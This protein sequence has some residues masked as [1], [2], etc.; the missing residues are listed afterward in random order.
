MAAGGLTGAGGGSIAGAAPPPLQKQPDGASLISYAQAG[1]PKPDVP[2]PGGGGDRQEG[3]EKREGGFVGCAAGAAKDVVVGTVKG[4]YNTAVDAGAA[5]LDKAGVG[6]FEGAADRTAARG[7]AIGEAA[8]GEWAEFK[9]EIDNGDSCA[10]GERVGTTVGVGATVVVGGGALYK[11]G[12]VLAKI[13]GKDGP[14]GPEAKPE[15]NDA[16]K[17]EKTEK[18]DGGDAGKVEETKKTSARLNISV[19]HILDGDINAKGKA[20]GFHHRAGGV[21]SPDARMK[22]RTEPEDMNGVYKGKVEIRDPDTGNWVE[23][24]ADS[25]FYP[26]RMSRDQVVQSIENAWDNKTSIDSKSGRFEGPSG[27]GFDI[28]GYARNGEIKTAYPDYVE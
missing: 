23:K 20:G 4:L 1:A 7:R 21:D 6:D 16:G 19:G 18:A 25:T 15:A 3:G 5:V 26:D 17:T 11:G 22:Q 8:S 2:K 14:D 12:K 24:K 9:A 28:I 27:E 13:G 10:L